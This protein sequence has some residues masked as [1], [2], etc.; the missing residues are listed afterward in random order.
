MVL[1]VVKDDDS[2]SDDNL[3]IVGRAGIGD[4][5]CAS[6]TRPA[7]RPDS[8]ATQ[9]WFNTRFIPDKVTLKRT[10]FRYQPTAQ[11]SYG[12]QPFPA[13]P[14]P[15]PVHLLLVSPPAAGVLLLATPGFCGSLFLEA[16]LVT[17]YQI[18]H[19]VKHAKGKLREINSSCS[20]S[21]WESIKILYFSGKANLPANFTN[22]F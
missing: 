17:K 3:P 21:S 5:K 7:C 13:T 1:E 6:W 11:G 9:T 10:A 18:E 4:R 22:S 16:R 20:T 12:S 2:D 19:S 14:P 8:K 15:S